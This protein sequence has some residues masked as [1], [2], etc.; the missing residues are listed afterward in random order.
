M[1]IRTNQAMGE[2]WS[3]SACLDVALFGQSVTGRLFLAM[4]RSH[5]QK[6]LRNTKALDQ[7]N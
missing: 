2:F 5:E 4:P 1:L 7:A 3:R 6:S